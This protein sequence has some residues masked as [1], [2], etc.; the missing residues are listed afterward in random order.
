MRKT[1]PSLFLGLIILLTPNGL[2]MVA[3]SFISANHT[4]TCLDC[5]DAWGSCKEEV[6]VRGH[7]GDCWTFACEAGTK[8]EHLIKTN[9]KVGAAALKALANYVDDIDPS[10]VISTKD[11]E[12]NTNTTDTQANTDA[13]IQAPAL[14]R[15]NRRSRRR[16]RSDRSRRRPRPSMFTTHN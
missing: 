2:S 5:S 16:A 15:P 7:I 3:G 12:A 6:K 8:N 10:V 11:I 9:D 1:I 14:V 13:A 4:N